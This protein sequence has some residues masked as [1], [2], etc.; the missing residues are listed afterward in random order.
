ML[1][2]TGSLLSVFHCKSLN[3]LS[4][5]YSLAISTYRGHWVIVVV[6]ESSRADRQSSCGDQL[7]RRPSSLMSS[8]S[9]ALASAAAAAWP[10]VTWLRRQVDN[11]HTTRVSILSL[12]L[13]L[14]VPSAGV[15]QRWFYRIAY[16]RLSHITLLRFAASVANKH[17]VTAPLLQ[18]SYCQL[19]LSINHNSAMSSNFVAEGFEDVKRLNYTSKCLLVSNSRIIICKEFSCCFY[20]TL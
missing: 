4:P 17:A 16:G 3:H 8:S 19:Q 11:T 12:L 13:L 18:S 1:D 14:P 15:V 5:Y 6:V 7:P 20:L 10:S 9:S 2:L